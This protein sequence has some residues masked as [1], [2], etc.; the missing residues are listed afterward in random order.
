M[1][2]EAVFETTRHGLNT[3][4]YVILSGP[5]STPRSLMNTV[6]GCV[7]LVSQGE[8]VKINPY[9][10]SLPGTEIN[11]EVVENPSLAETKSY[12][13][14][15]YPGMSVERVVR[16]LP[17]DEQA[18]EIVERFERRLPAYEEEVKRSLG[19]TDW[20]SEYSTPTQLDLLLSCGLEAK[21]FPEE[22]ALGLRARLQE[23][24]RTSRRRNITTREL[25]FA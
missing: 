12:P 10:Y 23:L 19:V 21:A 2:R 4:G 9:L 8:I 13:V 6:Q 3:V 5:V 15:G 1:N 25:T 22:W 16:L 17:R 20:I 11:K 24:L 18:R 14:P 7:D